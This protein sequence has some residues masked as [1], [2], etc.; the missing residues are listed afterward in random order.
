MGHEVVMLTPQDFRHTFPMPTY[1]E[2]HLTATTPGAVGRR[3]A[4]AAPDAIHVVTEGPLGMMARRWCR[5]QR[6][7][8]TTSF[9][10][11]FPD[12]IHARTR[13]PLSWGY[14]VQ[15][16][17]HNGGERLMVNTPTLFRELREKRFRNLVYWFRGVDLTLFRPRPEVERDALMPFPRPIWLYVGRIAVEKNLNAFLSLDLPGTKVLVGDGP[18]RAALEKAHPEV[19]FLGVHTGE[20]LA[21]LY[22]AADVFVFPSLTDTLGLVQMEALAS[23]IPVAA[24]PVPG[25]R[26]VLGDSGAG[27]MDED[28]GAACRQALDIPGTLCR[29]YAEKFSWTRSAEMFRDN[30]IFLD[31]DKR[32]AE[33]PGP[34]TEL[35]TD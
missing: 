27:V 18:S 21:R 4:A 24:F 26:D 13:L 16:W 17:F 29:A 25:P 20:D 8:F 6:L 34:H 7:P 9:H 5:R 22:V 19:R 33:W 12:Y 3:M 15:R 30:L 1:N 23:G 14:A 28:L 2:I 31:P 32:P 10:T 11:R 35:P